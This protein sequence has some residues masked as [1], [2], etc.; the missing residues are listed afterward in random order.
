MR[1]GSIKFYIYPQDHR[2]AH[3]HVIAA[4]AE[5]K[6]EILTG[7]CISNYGFNNKSIKALSRQVLTSQSELLEAW[8]EFEGEE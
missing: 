3:V 7:E 2:P 8:K 6:F 1:I 4:G 5:A